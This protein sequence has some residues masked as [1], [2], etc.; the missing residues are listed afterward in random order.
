MTTLEALHEEI[1]EIKSDVEKI[2]EI[3]EEY[4]LTEDAK[5]ALAEARST[6]E[7]EYIPH[8]DVKK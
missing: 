2:L 4:E 7:E 8:E 5:K 1:R 6:P 3:L